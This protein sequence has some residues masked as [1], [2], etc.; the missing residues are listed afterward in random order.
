MVLKGYLN[1]RHLAHGIE[2]GSHR[3]SPPAAQIQRPARSIV[4]QMPECT[5][6]GVGQILDVNVVADGSAVGRWVVGAEHLY[7]GKF[8]KCRLN[9]ERNQIG[10]GVML[11]TQLA[12]MIGSHGIEIAKRLQPMP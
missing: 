12:L 3:M 8:T 9:H 5:S 1:I 2:N 10:F 6:V 11:L 4:E 7:W